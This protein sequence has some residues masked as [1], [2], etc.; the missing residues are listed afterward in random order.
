MIDAVIG[1]DMGTG[2]ARAVAVDPDGKVLSSANHL[3]PSPFMD[4]SGRSEQLAQAWQTSA[5]EALGLCVSGLT[6]SVRIHA[7][8]VD[9]TS[10]S[11]V[12][13]DHE[14]RP[15]Y[16]GLMHNDSRSTDEANYLNDFLSAHCRGTGTQFGA[17]FSLAKILWLKRNETNLFDQ[18]A[19]ICHQ[20]DFILGGLTGEYGISD[21]S[22]SLK[23]GFNLVRKSW[24]SE[25]SDLGILE[26]MP[27]VEPS[28]TR[29]GFLLPSLQ[30]RFGFE[31][32]VE[33][34]SGTTDSTAAFLA[35]GATL[36][37]EFCN[38][39]GTT[40]AFKGISHELVR[41]QDG[42]VYSHRHP[43]GF[44]LPGGASN[45]GGACLKFFF[46]EKDLADLDRTAALRFPSNRLCYP[47]VEVGER[48]PFRNDRA[49]GFFDRTDSDAETHL[50]LLQG[51]AL[52]ERWG[53]EKFGELG[54]P[55]CPRV[56][57]TGSGSKSDHWCRIRA[58]TLQVPLVRPSSTD[59]AFGSA[60]LAASKTFYSG[61]AEAARRMSRVQIEFEPCPDFADWAEG[62]LTHLKEECR[63]R[64]LLNAD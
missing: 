52:V 14:N 28:G 30:K 33:V 22:N 57:A 11:I 2:G 38:T 27:R 4:R 55:E 64:G 12:F 6:N 31:D 34:L 13:L 35:S 8:C 61:L 16:P 36:P 18:V 60:V 56:F 46:P 9:A 58:N 25:F 24:P 42:V 5:V 45:V 54:M 1:L 21:P 15:L 7:I 62:M 53:L 23:S 43:D 50:Q 48:F 32:R 40:L 63:Q 39:I 17:T 44:W 49:Q 41:D 47:L 51:V 59:S 3:T 29:V 20:S 19:R 37:G 26:R 10:G